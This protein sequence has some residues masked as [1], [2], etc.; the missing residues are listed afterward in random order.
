M[1]LVE[2]LEVCWL[3]L[4][5]QWKSHNNTSMPDTNNMTN[6]AT[7]HPQSLVGSMVNMLERSDST[8]NY[9]RVISQLLPVVTRVYAAED[10]QQAVSTLVSLV[11]GPYLDKV[12]L[13]NG[14]LRGATNILKAI[15]FLFV[16][17]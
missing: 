4:L 6:M 8:K 16:M 15:K 1:L 14:L 9:A 10:P 3:H 13:G 2:G 17:P 7:L 12:S 5:L 11:L